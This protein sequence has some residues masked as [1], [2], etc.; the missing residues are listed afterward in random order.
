M[1]TTRLLSA[2]SAAALLGISSVALAQGTGTS[3][4]SSPGSSGGAPAGNTMQRQ[5]G[6]TSGSSAPSTQNPSTSGDRMSP[7]QAQ[8]EQDGQ[9]AN[10]AQGQQ[11]GKDGQK[12]QAQGNQMGRDAPRSNQAQERAPGMDGKSQ[13][14]REGRQGAKDS[15]TVGAAGSGA[16]NLSTE[17]RT[18]IRQQVLTERAPRAN[19]VNFQVNVGTVVPRDVR[20]VEVPPAIVKVR[21]AWRGYRYFVYN[22]EIVI[23]EPRTLKIVAVLE[24]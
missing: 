6:P 7:P 9:K 4:G 21:P 5:D 17:Q 18:T 24:V 11:M 23:V 22:D 2:V 8:R 12:S 10:R 3:P 13:M 1:K 15:A 16:V 14:S 19:N 20:V